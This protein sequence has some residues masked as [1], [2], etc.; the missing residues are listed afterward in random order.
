MSQPQQLQWIK[1]QQPEIFA[2]IQ[3][4]VAEGR[5]DCQGCIWVGESGNNRRLGRSRTENSLTADRWGCDQ[6]PIPT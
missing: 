3:A 6:S 1:E 4:R 2:Q 5:W